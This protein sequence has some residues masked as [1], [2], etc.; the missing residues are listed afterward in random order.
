MTIELTK[1]QYK[2]LIA[3]VAL[4]TGVLGIIGDAQPDDYKKK[5]GEMDEVESYLLKYAADFGCKNLA[6]PFRGKPSLNDEFYGKKIQPTLDDFED[7]VTSDGIA[8]E[9]AWRDFRKDHTEAEIKK[10]AKENHNYFGVELYDYEKKYWD[11]F[12]KNGYER[13]EIKNK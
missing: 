5:S 7:F 1:D 9:L 2:K 8:N 11:E 6:S 3:L 13:L 10:M 12:E 4:G